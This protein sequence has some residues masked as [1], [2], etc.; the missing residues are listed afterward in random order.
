MGERW[1]DRAKP[2]LNLT[3]CK[4]LIFMEVGK[5]ENPEKNPRSTG[6][7]NYN[8]ASGEFRSK[9]EKQPGVIPRWLPIQ[10]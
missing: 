4:V 3:T 6:E 1:T 2:Q 10:L 5:L 8:S 9:L 7:T